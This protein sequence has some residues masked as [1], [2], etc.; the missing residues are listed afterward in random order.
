MPGRIS[1]DGVRSAFWWWGFNESSVS[2]G[3]C[4]GKRESKLA[5]GNKGE[6]E[7]TC[8]NNTAAAEVCILDSK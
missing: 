8:E 7:V 6:K 3:T 4:E 2:G 5:T 1:G